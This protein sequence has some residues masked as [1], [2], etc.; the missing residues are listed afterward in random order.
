MLSS[1]RVLDLTDPQ[2]R[3]AGHVLAQHGADV[4]LLESPSGPGAAGT[5]AAGPSSAP[6]DEW[7][8]AFARGTRSV[9]LDRHDPG[10]IARLRA[11]LAR[12]DVLI[13][14]F[15]P[16]ERASLG[17]TPEE[18]TALYPRLVHASITPF[19]IDGPRAGWAATDLTVM[20]SAS[21]LAVTGDRDRPPVRMS[22]PQAFSFGAAAAA[23]AVLIALYEREA[24]GR[25][26]HVDVSAQTAAALATQTGLLAEA[27][28]LRPRSGRPVGHRW[29]R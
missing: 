21:P 1:V 23:G 22:V 2:C 18:T 20:A 25:G 9:A 3:L 5:S 24:S 12:A 29:A 28:G 11:L 10:A 26:Q 15:T 6:G 27:V 14:S 4:V 19:G 13:E 16:S 17:L 7:R 8:T